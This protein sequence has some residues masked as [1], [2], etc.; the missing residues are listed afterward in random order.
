MKENCTKKCMSH[1]SADVFCSTFIIQHLM[2]S[3]EN[4]FAGFILKQLKMLCCPDRFFFSLFLPCAKAITRCTLKFV[5]DLAGTDSVVGSSVEFSLALMTQPLT[6][7]HMRLFSKKKEGREE[8][9][10][11]NFKNCLTRIL[12]KSP[13]LLNSISNA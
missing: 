8:G 7:T 3:S 5:S 4:I 1:P 13:Q 6:F 9:N 12:G 2:S 10:C 11:E